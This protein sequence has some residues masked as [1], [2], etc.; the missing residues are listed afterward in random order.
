MYPVARENAF[1][2]L[3]LQNGLILHAVLIRF[4]V[5]QIFGYAR[6]AMLEIHN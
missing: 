5:V 6:I 2:T 4:K 1:F 3:K